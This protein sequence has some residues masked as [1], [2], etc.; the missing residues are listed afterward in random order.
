MGEEAKGG[1]RDGAAAKAAVLS[2]LSRR[3]EGATICPS[4][5]A[6]MLAEAGG[7]AD[8]RGE[9]AA[10]HRAVDGLVKEGVVQLS[11]QR[12]VLGERTGAYR[13]GRAEDACGEKA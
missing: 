10:V 5:P 13:I 2:L 11:W 7:S 8:W 1:E 12:K 9:M 4:E 3:A 6:R